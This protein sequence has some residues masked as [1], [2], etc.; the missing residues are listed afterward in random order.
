MAR[1]CTLLKIPKFRDWFENRYGLLCAMH[2]ADY[3]NKDKFNGDIRLFKGMIYKKQ[4]FDYI[5]ATGTFIAVQLPWV[6]IEYLWK[7][8]RNISTNPTS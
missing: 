1:H 3:D 7:K 6:W 2:D 4:P 5:F 8:Y